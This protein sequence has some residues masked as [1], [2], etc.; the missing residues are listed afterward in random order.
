MTINTLKSEKICCLCGFPITGPVHGPYDSGRRRNP[1]Y[2]CDRCWN[3]P[4]LWFSD[5]P[6][7]I[8]FARKIQE[9]R[10]SERSWS[11]TPDMR[12]A[13]GRRFP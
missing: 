8:E 1:D 4:F 3:M 7:C 6:D 5:R 13:S 10:Q 11:L 2:A 9:A 12:D